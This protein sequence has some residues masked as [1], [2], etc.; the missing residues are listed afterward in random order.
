MRPYRYPEDFHRIREFL[1]DSW[2]QTGGPFNWTFLRWEYARHSAVLWG[3]P[4]DGIRRWEDGIRIWEDE[5]GKIAAVVT[6]EVSVNN[7]DAWVFLNPVS[8]HASAEMIEYA[9]RSFCIREGSVRKLSVYGLEENSALSRIL[10]SMGYTAKLDNPGWYAEMSLTNLPSPALPQGYRIISAADEHDLQRKAM[11]CGKGFDHEDPKDWPSAA[12][13]NSMESAP[14]Y[15][16]ELDL[17][18]IAPDGEWVSAATFWY[19]PRSSVGVLEPMSTL[20][21][22]RRKGVG[23]AVIHE[24]A[25]RLASAG[26]KILSVGTLFGWD[27]THYYPAC[28][29][30]LKQKVLRWHKEYP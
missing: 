17:V 2:I 25:R 7:G 9:E 13:I 26:A 21:Q 22:H 28:G 12:M 27:T 20:P 16:P 24:G 23:R 4:V 5:S 14:S 19:E 11:T 30:K 29:F 3:D 1:I 15:R 6:N 10:S 18:A 8:P